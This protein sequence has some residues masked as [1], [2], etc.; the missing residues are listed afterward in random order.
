MAESVTQ[1]NITEDDI[2]EAEE[3]SEDVMRL[4]RLIDLIHLCKDDGEEI[5]S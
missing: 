3:L 5:Y 2:R 1:R 4:L